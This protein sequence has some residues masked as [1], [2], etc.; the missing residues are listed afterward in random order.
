MHKP[1][2]QAIFF[3]VYFN[4][5]WFDLPKSISLK[6]HDLKGLA[7]FVG[8]FFRAFNVL[9]INTLQSTPVFIPEGKPLLF[10]GGFESGGVKWRLRPPSEVENLCESSVS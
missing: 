8:R 4:S 10:D 7:Y 5:N 1:P 6:I 2:I 9:Y 3:A